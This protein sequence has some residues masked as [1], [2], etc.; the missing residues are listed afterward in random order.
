MLRLKP[1]QTN[2]KNSKVFSRDIL[3]IIEDTIPDLG[4]LT[5]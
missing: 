5:N 2:D 4:E 1:V 3:K